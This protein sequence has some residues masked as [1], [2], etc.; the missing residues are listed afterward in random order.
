MLNVIAFCIS[1]EQWEISNG[2]KGARRAKAALVCFALQLA[3]EHE[4]PNTFSGEGQVGM[5][6]GGCELHLPRPFHH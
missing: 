6:K 5:E 4:T 1:P 3:A 2:W